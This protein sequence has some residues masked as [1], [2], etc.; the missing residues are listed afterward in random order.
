MLRAFFLSPSWALWA[1][2]GLLLMLTLVYT[3]VQLLV[4]LNDWYREF[5][6]FLQSAPQIVEEGRSVEGVNTFW[7][8]VIQFC[9]I[10][11]PYIFLAMFT[12]F[13]ARHYTFR[14]RYALTFSYL[15]QWK[16]QT[17]EI[18]GASQRMQE[19]TYNFARIVQSLGLELIESF[20]KILSFIPILWMLSSYVPLPFFQDIPGS[21]VWA[22]LSLSVGGIIISWFV[23][24]KLP[25]LEYNNQKV[26]AAFRK[27]LVYAEDDKGF[28]D[29]PTLRHLFSDL[30]YNYF[31]LFLHYGYF[32]LWRISFIQF[33]TLVPLVMMGPG[34]FTGLSTLGIVFQAANSFDKVNDSFSYLIRSW[35]TITELRSI[36]KRLQEF[37]SNIGYRKKKYN[38]A[39]TIP[40]IAA[41]RP[42]SS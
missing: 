20:L 21:L 35:T 17:H 7:N 24:I 22:S 15:E 41:D 3:Q 19:D 11:I 13:L 30:R 18:E 32:D 6:N 27:Q 26:E 42:G 36:I 2:G 29:P 14:W 25:G 9:Y 39:S 33:A 23:G 37:E 5:Y 10:V 8:Y 12:Q 4:F 1:W 40:V 31:R 38:L 16:T 28:A 34:L